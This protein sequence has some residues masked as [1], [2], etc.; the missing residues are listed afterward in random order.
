MEKAIHILQGSLSS[1]LACRQRGSSQSVYLPECSSTNWRILSKGVSSVRGPMI[2]KYNFIYT[3]VLMRFP[4]LDNLSCCLQGVF[5]DG[6]C[7]GGWHRSTGCSGAVLHC[8]GDSR[9]WPWQVLAVAACPVLMD[10]L[11]E[12]RGWKRLLPFPGRADTFLGLPKK[13][14]QTKLRE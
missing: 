12:C 10:V 14:G 13:R 3:S 11:Q 6:G 2:R 9:T 7:C 4:E 1:L 8:P 5:G